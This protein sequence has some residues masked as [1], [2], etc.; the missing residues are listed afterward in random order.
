MHKDN[1]DPLK[2]NNFIRSFVPSRQNI[3]LIK[4]SFYVQIVLQ[5]GIILNMF[6]R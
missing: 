1:F 3:K 2:N 6:Y 5:I 4:C